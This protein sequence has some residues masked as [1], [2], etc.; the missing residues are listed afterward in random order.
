VVLVPVIC[1]HVGYECVNMIQTCVTYGGRECDGRATVHRARHMIPKVMCVVHGLP[2]GIALKM[3]V[4]LTSNWSTL[5]INT[6]LG[7]RVTLTQ[8][9]IYSWVNQRHQKTATTCFQAP[10]V[11][12]VALCTQGLG[13][14]IISPQSRPVGVVGDAE[15]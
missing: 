14:Y 7:F 10:S 2:S 9:S 4:G 5:P 6:F 1:G 8:K 3:Q 12:V 13:G 15:S 11:E